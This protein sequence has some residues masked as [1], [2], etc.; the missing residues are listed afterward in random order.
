MFHLLAHILATTVVGEKN[1]GYGFFFLKKTFFNSFK[2]NNT[3][4]AP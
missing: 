1:Q 3:V 4:Q 2:L